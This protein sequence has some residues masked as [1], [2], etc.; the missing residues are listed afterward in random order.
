MVALWAS[1]L[2]AQL[3][4]SA[5]AERWADVVDRRHHSGGAMILRWRPGPP[6]SGLSYAGAGEADAGRRGRGRA[7]VR[8]G[9]DRRAGG[10]HDLPGSRA[11]PVRAPA[12]C[13]R[14]LRRGDHQR[15]G[16]RRARRP[17]GHVVR[18]IAPGHRPRRLGLGRDL[19]RRPRAVE[20]QAGIEEMFVCAVQA[21][22]AWHQGDLTTARRELLSAQRLRPFL[23]FADPHQAIQA[24]LEVARVQ[25]GL[26][27]VAGARTLMREID[28]ILKRLPDLGTLVAD[29]GRAAGAAA[30]GRAPVVP[31]D[32]QRDVPVAAHGQIPGHVDLPQGSV[33]PR[34]TR[35]SRAPANWA[36]LRDSLEQPECDF[37]AD[38]MMRVRT[39]RRWV[40]VKGKGAL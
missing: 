23:T 12:R 34:G 30:A 19:R 7:A 6:C 22:V 38:R 17:G 33:P 18:A 40:V 26:G 31:G 24:R 21:R 28:E 4:R 9:G 11:G 25:L 37:H 20:R 15:R 27:D 13:R 32:R 16:S 2:A 3:G 1:V 29:N 8:G 39:G 14:G 35:P 10:G 5:E 36:S